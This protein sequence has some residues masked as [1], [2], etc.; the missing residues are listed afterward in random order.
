[1]VKI[2]TWN[3]NS[4][5]ARLDHLI[6]FSTKKDAPEII[7]L[8][9]L[10]CEEKNFPF[11][12]IE[13]AGFNVVVSCQKSYN[14]VAILSKYPI[15]DY[16]ITLAGDE[17]DSQARFIEAV[18]SIADK[19]IRVISVY[20]PNGKD[21][22]H[23]N[24]NYKLKYFDRL[25]KHFE[26]TLRF[27]EI[28]IVGGDFN[29]AP[30][31]L[32]DSYNPKHLEG[33]ICCHKLERQKYNSFLGQG[34]VDGFR[35][36]NP[37]SQQFTWWDYRGGSWQHNKGMRIDHFLLSSE[38]SIILKDCYVDTTPRGWARPSDHTPVICEIDI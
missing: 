37:D 28:F 27:E 11:E 29:V 22:E 4:V 23:E 30:Q 18:I 14:G 38:A 7:L 35:A 2:A 26:N 31:R 3:V 20:V 6:D 17:E 5:K 34:L 19:A 24:F 10:K 13:D 1:M 32:V 8:Q 33:T 9:E 15:D 16:N 21:P 12:A 36:K 25:Y